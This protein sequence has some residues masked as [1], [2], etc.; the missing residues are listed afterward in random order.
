MRKINSV[1]LI[2]AACFM[3]VT[4]IAVS[5][6][7]ERLSYNNPG[8]LVDLGVGLWA[9]P[10]PMDYNGNGLT[11][12]VVVC[13]DTPYNGVYFFENTGYNDQV[14]DLPVYKPAIRLG[15]AVN[16]ASISYV[17]GEPVVTTPG[18]FYPD[19]KNTAFD[20]PVNIP[21]PDARDLYPGDSRIRANQWK[22]VDYNNNNVQDLIVGIGLWGERNT[23][24]VNT[25]DGM[26]PIMRT[27]SGRMVPCVDI[28]IYYRIWEALITP[29]TM[30]PGSF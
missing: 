16:N 24:V 7:L 26:T 4:P 3:A 9:W 8:L 13:T 20:N 1:L 11:D 6:Q 21:A 10:L 17:N 19:F 30:I 23:G 22:F 27:D 2:I 15:D 28:S 18:R 5:Q 25:M 12:L 14:T 29:F